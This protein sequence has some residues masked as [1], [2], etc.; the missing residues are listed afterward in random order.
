MTKVTACSTAFIIFA[1]LKRI[2]AIFLLGIYLLSATEAHQLLRVPYIFQ[3]FAAHRQEDKNITFLQFLDMH[4][5]HGSPKD[6]DYND[7][8][9]LPFK[10][11]DNCNISWSPAYLPVTKTIF[12]IRTVALPKLKTTLYDDDCAPSPYLSHIWQPPKSC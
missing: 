1:K 4:Y 12:G 6:K 7:D 8:M 9:K 11:V 3:H 5:M 10:S 2:I